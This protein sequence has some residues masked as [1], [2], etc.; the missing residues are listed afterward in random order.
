MIKLITE[1][2]RLKKNFFVVELNPDNKKAINVCFCIQ[3]IGIFLISLLL[4][5][6]AD[7]GID[8]LRIFEK[9]RQ[10]DELMPGT[11]L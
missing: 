8:S 5:Y 3:K 9:S 7:Q 2:Y 11:S 10:A 6:Y 1:A 4:M